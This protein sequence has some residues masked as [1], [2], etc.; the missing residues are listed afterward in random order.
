MDGV[1]GLRLFLTVK[2]KKSRN[3]DAITARL[4]TEE[5]IIGERESEL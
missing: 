2:L 5:D 4:Y 3:R 1:I